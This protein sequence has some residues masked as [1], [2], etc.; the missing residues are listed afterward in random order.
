MILLPP[1]VYERDRA[2][3]IRHDMSIESLLFEFHEQRRDSYLS[4]ES[5]MKSLGPPECPRFPIP[6]VD[7][8]RLMEMATYGMGCRASGFRTM[9]ISTSIPP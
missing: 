1:A 6:S 3:L 9:F 8:A 2:S 4:T 5:V 7:M